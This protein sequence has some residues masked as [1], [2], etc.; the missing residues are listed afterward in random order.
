MT[1]DK[2]VD[3][4]TGNGRR[5][6]VF[7]QRSPFSLGRRLLRDTG[8]QVLLF[9]AVLVVAILAF[10][11]VIP[12]G[13]QV[14][15]QRIR[16]QTAADAGS[17]TGSVWLARALNLNANMNIGIKSDYTWMTVF[18]MGEA[19]AQALYSDT[20]DPSAKTLGQNI[21]LALFGSSNPVTVHSIEYPG[22]IRK[23]DTTAQWLYALQGDMAENFSDVAANMGT[24]EACRNAGAYPPSQTAGGSAIVRANY[25]TPLLVQNATGDSLMYAA[26]LQLPTALGTIPINDTTVGAATGTFRVDSHN[27]EIKAYYSVSS[28]MYDVRQVINRKYPYYAKQIYWLENAVSCLDAD[29][30]YKCFDTKNQEYTNYVQGKTWI[31]PHTNPPGQVWLL[32][33]YSGGTNKYG[34]DTVVYGKHV[35]RTPSSKWNYHPYTSGKGMCSDAQPHVTAGDSI[36]SS[37]TIAS[38]DHYTAAESTTGY[39]GPRVRPRRVNPAREFHTVSYVWRQAA[40]TSPYGLGAPL[41]G[42]LFPRSKVAAPSPMLTVARSKTYLGLVTPTQYDYFFTPAWDVK[43]TPMDSTGLQEICSDTGFSGHSHNSF[44]LEALRKYALLP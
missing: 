17:F 42:K 27:F 35:C 26:L 4:K 21:T 3:M 20:L 1:K 37:M 10:L 44:N 7:G 24:E 16:A 43:L 18:T 30:A 6:T 19:L 38:N 9:A 12:N 34:R 13:T 11:L 22:S 15:T 29:T 39:Q 25:S 36:D 8:G 2:G 32:H 28:Q 31:V 33:S 41:G 40:S 14:T 23:L 5:K